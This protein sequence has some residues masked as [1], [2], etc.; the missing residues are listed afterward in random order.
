MEPR[1]DGS[2][3]KSLR[4]LKNNIGMDVIYGT[5]YKAEYFPDLFCTTDKT[6]PYTRNDGYIAFITEEELL[7]AKAEALYWMG[8]KSEARDVTLEAIR[9]SFTRYGVYGNLDIIEEER[10]VCL[11]QALQLRILCNKN[12]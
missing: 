12:M 2:K 6:N 4:S 10:Y 3:A 7:F 11:Q 8:R 9:A 1:L 5:D